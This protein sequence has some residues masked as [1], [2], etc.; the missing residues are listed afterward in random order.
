MHL[1]VKG[2]EWINKT[3]AM[4]EIQTSLLKTHGLIWARMLIRCQEFGHPYVMEGMEGPHRGFAEIPSQSDAYHVSYMDYM[5]GQQQA[6]PA[7]R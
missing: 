5:T 6:F 2:G 3:L 4:E 7:L 1:I